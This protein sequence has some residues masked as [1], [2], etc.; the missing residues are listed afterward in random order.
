MIRR[1]RKFFELRRR[2]RIA[3][4]LDYV[5]WLFE[6]HPELRKHFRKT[7]RIRGYES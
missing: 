7:L 6:T 2:R 5:I 3:R 4:D 1:I